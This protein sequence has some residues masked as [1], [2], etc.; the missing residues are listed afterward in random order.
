MLIKRVVGKSIVTVLSVYAPQA[1]FNDSVKDLF[2]E[3]IQWTPI[4][5]SA[6]E[7]LFVCGDFIGH[8]GKNADEYKRVHGGRR[9]ERRN[10]EG[11]RILEFAVARNLVVSN[12]LFTKRESHLVTYQSGEIQSQID[13]ILIKWQ[14]IK[15]VRDVKVIPHKDCVTQQK[16]L[17]CDAR[18]IKSKNRC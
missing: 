8:I 6:S 18:I 1:G 14:N 16:L 2:Y 10:L 11:E 5:I 12:L 3:N 13:Y 7:I 4:K 17:A 15:L 9:F